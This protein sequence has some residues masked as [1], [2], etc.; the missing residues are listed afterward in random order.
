MSG[1]LSVRT[2]NG[3][4]ARYSLKCSV[5]GSGSGSQ[6]QWDGTVH[7]SVSGRAPLPVPPWRHPFPTGKAFQSQGTLGQ[8]WTGPFPLGWPWPPRLQGADP[9]DHLQFLPQQVIQGVR[10]IGK[11]LDKPPVVPH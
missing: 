7:H 2:T 4:Y 10:Y 8:A 1:L 9:P 5:T 3:A 6:R 11:P